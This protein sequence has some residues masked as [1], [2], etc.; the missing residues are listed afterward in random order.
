MLAHSPPPQPQPSSHKFDPAGQTLVWLSNRIGGPHNASA[1]LLTASW[2]LAESAKTLAAKVVVDVAQTAADAPVHCWQ[3]AA[4]CWLAADRLMLGTEWCGRPRLA[5]VDLTS[6][7]MAMVSYEAEEAHSWSFFFGGRGGG[8]D[9]S[10]PCALFELVSHIRRRC[11]P[12]HH[13]SCCLQRHGM[14]V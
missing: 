4:Q 13:A 6:N 8:Q 11:A 5:V 1:R 12:Q 14:G 9:I 3:F 10:P 2:P 7:T